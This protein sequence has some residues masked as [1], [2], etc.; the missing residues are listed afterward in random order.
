MCDVKCHF[1]LTYI[2]WD[3]W[4]ILTSQ[5]FFTK[6]DTK[7]DEKWQF[8]TFFSFFKNENF[9][10]WS[11]PFKNLITVLTRFHEN[12]MKKHENDFFNTS[13]KRKMTFQVRFFM[14]F[15]FFTKCS[16]NMSGLIL[17]KTWKNKIANENHEKMSK[18]HDFSILSHFWTPFFTKV[19]NDDFCSFSCLKLTVSFVSL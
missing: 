13:G 11:I 14:I 19:K 3:F 4:S 10:F 2:F 7:N 16:K 8:F 18:N 17:E 15:V 12:D 6:N 5:L 9:H 1:F